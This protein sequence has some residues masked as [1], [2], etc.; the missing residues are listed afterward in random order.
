[1]AELLTIDGPREATINL[2][3]WACQK[4]HPIDVADVERLIYALS[5]GE[6]EAYDAGYA[7]GTHGVTIDETFT[8]ISCLFVPLQRSISST[9]F[10]EHVEARIA[11]RMGS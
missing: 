5:A 9:G 1:M 7:N 11:V 6:V 4:L 8:E 3:C 10:L 2:Y